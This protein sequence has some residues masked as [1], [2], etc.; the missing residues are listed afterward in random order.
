VPITVSTVVWVSVAVTVVFGIVPTALIH[1]A[2][3]ATLLF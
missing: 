3:K 1:L 2:E